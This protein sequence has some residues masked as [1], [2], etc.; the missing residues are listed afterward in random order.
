M[1][2]K[3]YENK[4][5][6]DEI[7]DKISILLGITGVGKS[8]FIN[9]ITKKKECKV[10]DTTKA[11]T[12]EIKQADIGNEGYNFYFVDTPGLDDGKG[13]AKNIAQLDSVRKKY[14]RINAFIISLKFDDLRLSSSL[15]MAL[16]KFMDIFPTPTFWDH[17][18]ILRTHAERT[19]K[20]EKNKAK[21]EG[22]LLEGIQEDKDL[23]DYMKTNSINIPTKLKEFFV[24]SETD[25]DDELDEGTLEEFQKIFDSIREIHPIYKEV[26]EE[27]K[28]Y[29]NEEK[30]EGSA[31]IHIKTDKHILFKDFDGQEHETVQTV[32]DERYNLDN[33]R[34]I[35][36]EV[37]REQAK[38]P[39]G[40]WCW[41]NQFKTR[42]YLVK[43][44][45]INGERKRVECEIEWRWEYKGEEN[46]AK[47][48]EYREK[49]N[50]R[51]NRDVCCA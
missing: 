8:S 20:F 21:V 38:E 9:A 37:K 31:F 35:L 45:Q 36:I 24:D 10:G 11:C 30:I 7:R 14:P 19:K 39:R 50:E 15:K 44:Y 29:V 18:L 42:Y 1:G 4:F 47:G 2:C 17:V 51:Y 25:S 33:Y 49:L 26:K 3:A 41:S 32:L 12:Q 16:K 34:P 5:V 40:I 46:D 22:K 27:I 13:D 43:Y 28:E 23:I 48:E 6:M